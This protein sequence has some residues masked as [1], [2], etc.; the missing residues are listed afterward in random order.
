[1]KT[2]FTYII[3]NKKHG[4]L[5]TGMTNDVMSRIR[6]HSNNKLNS[7][8][9]KYKLNKLVWFEAFNTPEEAI[10]REKEIKGWLR[11]KKIDLIEKKNPEWKDLYL[12]LRIEMGKKYQPISRSWSYQKP[13]NSS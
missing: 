3:T 9:G 13:N 12:E 5:Y 6:H 8:T 1:M 2:Y 11:S 4:S 7:F 10:R